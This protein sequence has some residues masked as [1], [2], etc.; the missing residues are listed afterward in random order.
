MVVSLVPALLLLPEGCGEA[1]FWSVKDTGA[2]SDAMM[3]MSSTASAAS[4]GLLEG[5]ATTSSTASEASTGLLGGTATTS[6]SSGSGPVEPGFGC[7]EA[8]DYLPTTHTRHDIDGDGIADLHLKMGDVWKIDFAHDGF[9]DWNKIISGFGSTDLPAPADYDGDGRT[10][11]G[12]RSDLGV[13]VIDYSGNCLGAPP[14]PGWDFS[15]EGYGGPPFHLV[16]ADYDGD[17]KDDFSA[18]GDNGFWGIAFAENGLYPWNPELNGYGDDSFIPCPADYDGDGRVD[19]SA[20]GPTAWSI[21][22][23]S[24]GFWGVGL[25]GWVW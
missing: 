3:T 21:D 16:P 10:D 1:G 11:L 22:F 19:L 24:D 9:G 12:A 6:G 7:G 17:L 5:T 2:V 13:W 14:R 18:K 8:D 20:K 25:G 4:T 15:H 23:A